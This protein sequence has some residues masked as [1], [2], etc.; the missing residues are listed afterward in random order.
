[1]EQIPKIVEQRLRATA[2]VGPHPDA[3]NK[4]G[5]KDKAKAVAKAAKVPTVPGSD[6][7]VTHDEEAAAFARKV[8]YPV[9]IKAAAGGGG[10]GMRPAWDDVGL[11]KGLAEARAEAEISFKDGSVFLEKYLDKPRHVEV[12][13]IGDKHGN[14]IREIRPVTDSSGNVLKYVVTVHAYQ[15]VDPTDANLENAVLDSEEFGISNLNKLI[16]ATDYPSFEVNAGLDDQ[17]DLQRPRLS[18][19]ALDG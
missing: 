7:I 19:G 8:G 2:P 10:K 15:Y 18:G 11:V 9:L 14:V 17:H 1:M 3:M 12:Q 13:L 5:N 6:G 16:D 4:L